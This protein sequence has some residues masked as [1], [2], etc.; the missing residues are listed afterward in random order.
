MADIRTYF[1]DGAG[2]WDISAPTLTEDDGL[3]TAVVLS[4]FTDAEADQA[5]ELPN[6]ASARR[7]WWG[8]AYADVAGDRI[9]SRLWLLTRS[10]RTPDVVARAQQYAREALQWLVD[11]GIASAVEV[12][13][14]AMGNGALGL[15]VQI[16]RSAKPV[17]RFRF[18]AFW[19]GA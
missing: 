3:E 8:D 6:D 4:L 9:G 16:V 10:K 13:A 15:Q 7:G 17:A 2:Y 14:E 5:D 18:E 19:K 1:R 12:L 11:D